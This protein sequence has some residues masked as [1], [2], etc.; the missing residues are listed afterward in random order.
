MLNVDRPFHFGWT[1][2]DGDKETWNSIDLDKVK[3][4]RTIYDEFGIARFLIKPCTPAGQSTMGDCP[5]HKIDAESIRKS[6]Q[7][8]TVLDSAKPKEKVQS[9]NEYLNST[10]NW[11]NLK[12]LPE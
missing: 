8:I 4:D 7:T 6:I 9:E 2:Q 5:A 3:T 12:K 10:Y 1:H 11:Q